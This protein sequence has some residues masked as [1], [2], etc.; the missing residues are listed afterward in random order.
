MTMI[1]HYMTK[2]KWDPDSMSMSMTHSI[3]V[4]MHC[5]IAIGLVHT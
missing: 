4:I 2:I 1:L 3:S 5:H